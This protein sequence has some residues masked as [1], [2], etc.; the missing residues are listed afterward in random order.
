MTSCALT[1]PAE[2]ISDARALA[3][4]DGAPL[5][6]YLSSLVSERIG[7]LKAL[8]HVQQRIARANRVEALAMLR[9]APDLP[10]VEGDER[11]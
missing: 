7:E 11:A 2:I 10:P 1:L 6:Q 3:A 5:D 8:R 9:R 4:A